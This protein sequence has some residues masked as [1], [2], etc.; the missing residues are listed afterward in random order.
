MP[1]RVAQKNALHLP[2][3]GLLFENQSQRTDWT[4]KEA[5]RM[6]FREICMP[7]IYRLSVCRR[8]SSSSGGCIFVAAAARRMEAKAGGRW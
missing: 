2:P 6:A 3:T 1:D 8:P 4:G 5:E 7:K